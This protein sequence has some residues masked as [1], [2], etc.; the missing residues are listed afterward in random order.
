MGRE[1]AAEWRGWDR[2]GGAR[3][4]GQVGT[5]G[6][7][8][9]PHSWGWERHSGTPEAQG[10]ERD[11]GVCPG[12]PAGQRIRGLF[13]GSRPEL[14]ETPRSWGLRGLGTGQ[15]EP[16]YAS[17]EQ[18]W[19]PRLWVWTGPPG[20]GLVR[21][22]PR[23]RGS[24]RGRQAGA[25]R[26]GGLELPPGKSRRES[27]QDG[28]TQAGHWGGLGLGSGGGGTEVRQRCAGE[29]LPSRGSG[30]AGEGGQQDRTAQETRAWGVL[31]KGPVGGAGGVPTSLSSYTTTWSL[32]FLV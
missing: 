11:V 17:H 31:S 19:G 23:L 8:Q 24:H 20:R 26:P 21:S 15:R 3:E 13:S 18:S 1:R 4:L 5:G 29:E 28:A 10:G 6:A 9:R 14:P 22:E 25:R 2:H 30:L 32:S 27:H 12:H 7:P 16:P